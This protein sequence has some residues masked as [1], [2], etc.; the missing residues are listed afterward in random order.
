MTVQIRNESKETVLVLEG[1]VDGAGADSLHSALHDVA[2]ERQVA[3]DFHLV[4]LFNDFAVAR[5][6][7]EIADRPGNLTLIGLSERHHRLL[8]Y[9]ESADHLARVNHQSALALWLGQRLS[10]PATSARSSQRNAVCPDT[11]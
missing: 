4:R 11:V 6:V 2:R 5:L 8:R 10:R 3:I 1:K 9:V 7:Q